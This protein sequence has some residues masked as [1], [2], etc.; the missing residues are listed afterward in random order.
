MANVVNINDRKY[1]VDVGYGRDGPSRPVPLVPE[2]EVEGLPGQMLKLEHKRL[3]QHANT[4]Q[5]VWV[6]SQLNSG[7]KWTEVYHF[8]DVEMFPADFDILNLYNM[9]HSYFAQHVVAQRFV[10]DKNSPQKSLV[11][12]ILLVRDTL[13]FYTTEQEATVEHLRTEEERIAA[14]AD[15]FGIHLNTQQRE[16]IYG[17]NNRLAIS[18]K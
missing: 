10:L 2:L 7:G 15:H 16:A 17:R 12:S 5:R 9:Q 8:I 4:D 3:S 6:Y 14:L 1:L 11:G 13:A 18:H